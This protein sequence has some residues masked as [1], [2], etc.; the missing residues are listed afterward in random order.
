MTKKRDK[1]PLLLRAL[2]KENK[3]PPKEELSPQVTEVGMLLICHFDR[4]KAESRNL[5]LFL[6]EEY[7]AA[8]SCF[9]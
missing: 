1:L 3:A 5:H 6:A 7:R 2:H 4:S 8:P 9:S